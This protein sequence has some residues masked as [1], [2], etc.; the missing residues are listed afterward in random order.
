MQLATLQ[1]PKALPF[2]LAHS[3]HGQAQ[4]SCKETWP[5]QTKNPAWCVEFVVLLPVSLPYLALDTTFT[6]LF[7]HHDKS[8]TVRIDRKAGTATLVC[9]VCDQRFEGKANRT[10]NSPPIA[11]SDL[12]TYHH[13]DLTEAIDIYSEWIDAADAAQ[14]DETVARRPGG[15]S[16]RVLPV[17]VDSDF[18]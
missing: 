14:R 17:Q 6:C 2:P 12:L 11:A 8:V 10:C 13:I 3:H 15:S 16:G 1:M 4:E 7:C 9:K 5:V 18:E